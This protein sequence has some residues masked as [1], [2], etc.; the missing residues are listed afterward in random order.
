MEPGA[1]VLR[2][3]AYQNYQITDPDAP[4]DEFT[5]YGIPEGAEV[6]AQ[7]EDFDIA[8][9]MEFDLAPFMRPAIDE[10]ETEIT[11]AIKEAIQKQIEELIK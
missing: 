8:A 10:N 2:D 11:N 9:V 6:S 5:Y 7:E 1:K 3:A 4:A